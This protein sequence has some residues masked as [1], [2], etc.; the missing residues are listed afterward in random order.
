MS[1]F[2]ERLRGCAVAAVALAALA[3]APQAASAAVPAP[4]RPVVTGYDA[5]QVSWSTPSSGTPVTSYDLSV[6]G[7]VVSHL[8]PGTR[9][10]WIGNTR[11]YSSY[12]IAV[13]AV[14]D[15]GTSQ[16]VPVVWKSPAPTPVADAVGPG[17]APAPTSAAALAAPATKTA[18]LAAATAAATSPD[19]PLT[20]LDPSSPLARSVT[21]TW[22]VIPGVSQ[23]ELTMQPG[24]V[25]LWFTGGPSTAVILGLLPSTTYAVKFYPYIPNQ[26]AIATPAQF[27]TAP[28]GNPTPSPPT[29]PTNV[30][31]NATR[32]T[33][34]ISWTAA[35]DDVRVAGYRI[36]DGPTLVT[37]VSGLTDVTLYTLEPNHHYDYTL[38]A[39]DDDGLTSPPVP[40]SFS[41]FSG[42]YAV[43]GNALLQRVAKGS[44]PLKGSITGATFSSDGVFSDAT[45]TSSLS[46][47][48]TA[49]VKLTALGFLPVTAQLSFVPVTPLAGAISG[50]V[51]SANVGLRIKLPSISA[52]GVRI[53]GGANCQTTQPSSV[54]LRSTGTTVAGAATT[55]AGTFAISNLSG[56]GALTG[57]VSPLTAGGGNAVSL[58]LAPVA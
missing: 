20:T 15:D 12:S 56:C 18:T 26:P 21:V 28:S 57:L 10:V 1:R 13:Q 36:Y 37:Q 23:Y 24:N 3:A 31:V 50:G 35:T 6:D 43:T 44:I 16:A 29:A 46:L 5:P 34:A 19:E 7:T 55:L 38:T 42:T 40:I 11:Y 30:R 2:S 8:D 51:L 47:D 9:A 4:I 22:G 25:N 39:Y 58:Q 27:T 45:F 52:L 14:T 33:A 41:T 53:A 17:A 32:S 48:D 54:A 49:P